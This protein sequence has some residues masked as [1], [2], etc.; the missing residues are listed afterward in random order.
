MLK[1]FVYGDCWWSLLLL[2]VKLFGAPKQQ[3]HDN[4]RDNIA[5][6]IH[7]HQRGKVNRGQWQIFDK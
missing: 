7:E 1:F 3:F 4:D 6:E 2:N 5:I